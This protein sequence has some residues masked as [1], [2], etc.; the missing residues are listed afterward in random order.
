MAEA[1]CSRYSIHPSSTKMY[2][3]L[4]EIYWWNDIK[5]DIAE[6]VAQCF[7]YQQVK[8]EHQR[9]DCPAQTFSLPVWKWDAM[10]IYH[11][12]IGIAPLKIYMEDDVDRLLV[13]PMKGVM[14]FGKKGKLSPRYIEPY[15]VIRRIGQVAYELKLPPEL[16]AVH[17][18]FH[19]SMLRKYLGESSR[20][21][22]IEGIKLV[23]DLSF[24]EVPVAILDRQVR[25]LRSRGIASIKV[26]RRNQNIEE[27]TWEAEADMKTKYPYL[28]QKLS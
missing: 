28:I 8:A 13:S 26:L 24:P 2:L 6:Y 7:N 20:V 5:K 11:F 4:K 18:V 1:H 27:A 10:N 17:H 3:G 15:R 14:R 19:V 23:G 12:S 16:V 25:K 21:I 9:P 22:P